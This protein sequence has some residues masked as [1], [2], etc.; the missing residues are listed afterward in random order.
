MKL[1]LQTSCYIRKLLR[2]W[3]N[4]SASLGIAESKLLES[5]ALN[6]LM[7]CYYDNILLES[8]DLNML[9]GHH[10]PQPSERMLA[11]DRLENLTGLHNALSQNATYNNHIRELE[12]LEQQILWLLGNQNMQLKRLVNDLYHVLSGS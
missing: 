3:A 11:I 7:G 10:Y 12:K 2:Y 4:K 9:L 8:L 5:L 6:T 1:S